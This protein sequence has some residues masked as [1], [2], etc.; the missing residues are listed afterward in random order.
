VRAGGF[1][2]RSILDRVGLGE[3]GL[4]LRFGWRILLAVCALYTISFLTFYPRVITN[5]DEDAYVRHAHIV[6]QG[7]YKVEKLDALTG[8]TSPDIVSRYPIGNAV[9]MAPFV[10][11]AGWRGAFLVPLLCLLASVLMLGRWLEEEGRSPVW[12]LLALGYPVALLMGR[13][14]MSDIP[15]MVVVTLGLWLFWRGP[16][17]NG[18]RWLASGFVAGASTIW[19]EPN[20]VAFIPF[21]A[22]AALRRAPGWWKLVA[23]GLLGLAVRLISTTLVFGQPFFYKSAPTL[24]LAGALDRLPTYL[25]TVL[26][27]WPGGLLVVQFY[28]GRYRLELILAVNLFLLF[29]LLQD[30][31]M[32]GVSLPRQVILT[33]RYVFP[34]LP[35]L[36]I[37]HAEVLPRLWSR[38]REATPTPRRRRLETAAAAVLALWIAGVAAAAVA[39]HPLHAAWSSPMAQIREA[40]AE[41]TDPDGVIVTHVEFA[42]KFIDEYDRK[43]LPTARADLTLEQATDLA[44]RVGGFQ[45]VLLERTDGAYGIEQAA[46]NEEFLA[47]I[48]PMKPVLEFDRRF[49]PI[50]RLRIWRVNPP[51]TP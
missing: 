16:G 26:V 12:A 30:F 20:A 5:D 15:S 9:M 38:L 41:H 50:E 4:D 48:E 46:L 37:A 10:A 1:F 42:R 23:G 36:A 29:Y 35:L 21:F 31:F 51:E 27:L 24:D 32:W 8:E 13:I 33:A 14:C 7:K 45:I 11:L 49:S 17:R 25:A 34:I 22:S 18:G 47:R 6:F 39:V 40:I 28:R 19:R 3:A 44:R 43:Y 2:D